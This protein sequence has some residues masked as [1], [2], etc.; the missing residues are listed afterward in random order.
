MNTSEKVKTT[1]I[2]ANLGAPSQLSEVRPFLKNLFNDPDIFNFPFGKFGQELFSSL[3]AFLRSPKSQK[4]YAAI[5]GGSPLHRNTLEQAQKLNSALNT[6][7]DY[8]VI[9]MQRYW[10]PSIKSSLENLKL[11]DHENIIILP[12][13]PHF[14]NTTTS[15]IFNEWDRHWTG[16]QHVSRIERFYDHPLYIKACVREIEL[17]Q[18]KLSP[19]VHILFSAHSIPQSAIRNGDT[20]ETEIENNME[21]I[22]A[23]LDGEFSYSLAYQSRVGPIKWLE[24]S[25]ETEID[26]LISL[27]KKEILIFPI[28]FV[29]E[30]LETLYEL[31]IQKKEWS[32]KRGIKIYARAKTVQTSD[33]FIAALKDMVLKI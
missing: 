25:F 29:S 18:K 20:Y 7:G 19:A 3:I 26:R 13:Y 17:E 33:L 9:V 4:Y 24:P 31:D 21:L 8:N 12:L 2:L 14:S 16:K 22:M 1:V 27:Q 11:D 32:L 23:E 10:E 30:H 6:E 28:S 5:G 15:S